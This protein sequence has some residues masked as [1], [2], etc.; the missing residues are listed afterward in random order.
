MTHPPPV[1]VTPEQCET[2]VKQIVGIGVE[3]A[4]GKFGEAVDSRFEALEG[5]VSKLARSTDSICR[6]TQRRLQTVLDGLPYDW[7]GRQLLRSC[8]DMEDTIF[9]LISRYTDRRF[10]VQL[11]IAEGNFYMMD[12]V[13]ET[14]KNDAGLIETS[15]EV[16]DVEMPDLWG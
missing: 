9:V 8:R 13:L 15:F 4:L 14:L 5:Q 3:A 12:A 2:T 6:V 10:K 16:E 7:S 1:A 11:D